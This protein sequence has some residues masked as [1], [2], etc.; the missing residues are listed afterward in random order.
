MHRSVD[1]QTPSTWTRD[2]GRITGLFLLLNGGRTH[3]KRIGM[4]AILSLVFTNRFNSAR[5]ERS[6]LGA[7]IS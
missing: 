2:F 3:V 1:V 6:N 5:D 7:P 4:C